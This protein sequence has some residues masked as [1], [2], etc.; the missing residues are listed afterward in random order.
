MTLMAGASLGC[1][2]RS[3]ALRVP[4]D[5]RDS[6]TERREVPFE[7]LR[8]GIRY[9][10][11]RTQQLTLMWA[12]P[13]ADGGR[14]FVGGCFGPLLNPL[15]EGEEA[16]CRGRSVGERL[17]GDGRQRSRGQPRYA[18]LAGGVGVAGGVNPLAMSHTPRV[19]SLMAMGRK[20]T[21]E[22]VATGSA[23]NM[24]LRPAAM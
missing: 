16:G 4:Q 24:I 5:E 3:L 12:G 18:A 19:S 2:Q 1:V 6:D 15:P 7:R 20:R 8:A 9:R 23:P 17:A 10:S 21:M 22:E 13:V 11:A 14:W